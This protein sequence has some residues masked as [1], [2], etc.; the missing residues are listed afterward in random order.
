MNKTTT[1]PATQVGPSFKER[2]RLFYQLKFLAI[3]AVSI[4]AISDQLTDHAA[5]GMELLLEDI[6]E[7]IFPEN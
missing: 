2:E 4:P 3:V 5:Y 1:T 7:Q 6:A